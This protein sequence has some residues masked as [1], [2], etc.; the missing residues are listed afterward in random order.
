MSKLERTKDDYLSVNL[1]PKDLG[2]YIHIPFCVRK[3]DYC[4]FL[5]APGN[6]QSKKE[7]VKALLAEV[8]SYEGRTGGYRVQTIFIG[9]GTPSCID[10]EDIKGIMEAIRQVFHVEEASLEAT[11]E[12]NP[13]TI[14]EQKLS[15]Y[16]EAGINRISFGLQSVD[17]GELKKLGRIH[18]YED[19]R[20]NYQLART[21]GFR[22]IN[23]DLMSALPGQTI[24]SWESTLRRVAELNPE[25]ISAYSLIIEEGTTFYVRYRP[26]SSYEKDLPDEDEDR[27][28]Y[29]MTKQILKEYGYHRYEISNYAKSSYECR[30][31]NSYWIGTD[32]LGLG[33]G[34]ASYVDGVRFSN[35][36]DSKQY[37][38]A[39]NSYQNEKVKFEKTASILE[40]RI[41]IR[42][43]VHS[44]SRDEQMEEFM[45]LGLRR[46]EGISKR[47]FTE[48]FQITID[49][50][51]GKVLLVLQQK[52][53][54]DI[55]EERIALTEYG[56]DISNMVLAEFLLN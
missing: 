4:D 7:Y 12:V 25:H 55:T 31:N 48:R 19:F 10:P 3:C 52:E 18:S 54:I 14:S 24:V 28:I 41:R 11:I 53:L 30:H 37:I 13:G 46:C 49:Q 47:D 51:Y 5:S 9:G 33:L 15:C 56:I 29:A 36:Q 39:C 8:Q 6:E 43:E 34:S 21:L 27:R 1:E 38:A 26:G 23:V 45:F 32:Y 42:R 22:N 44:L 35:I 2:L 40:D 20:N 50:I 17:S 16:Q